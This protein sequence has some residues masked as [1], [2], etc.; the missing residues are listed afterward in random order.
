MIPH[1]VL[2]HSINVGYAGTCVRMSIIHL[3]LSSQLYLESHLTM[4][5]DADVAAKLPNLT[6]I[7]M[8]TLVIVAKIIIIFVMLGVSL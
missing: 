3:I 6:F 1:E 7:N 4:A 2:N 5:A 8:E